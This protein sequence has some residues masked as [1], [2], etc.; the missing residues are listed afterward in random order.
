MTGLYFCRLE[1]LS[2]LNKLSVV[3]G[4][5]DEIKSYEKYLYP[6]TVRVCVYKRFSL[7][8]R[9]ALKG[10]MEICQFI[11]FKNLD[12]R[13]LERDFE[14]R[15]KRYFWNSRKRKKKTQVVMDQKFNNKQ[16]NL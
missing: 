1:K 5:Y 13:I 9:M 7:R 6:L 10:E 12:F 14:R 3:V 11:L 8:V 4:C 2:F 15:S 16:T